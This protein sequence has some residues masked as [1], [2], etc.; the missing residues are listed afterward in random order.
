MKE[1]ALH[2]FDFYNCRR[3]FESL[4]EFGTELGPAIDY[5][6]F[7]KKNRSVGGYG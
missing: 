2:H 6:M 5:Q 3:V 7:E 1:R 4:V